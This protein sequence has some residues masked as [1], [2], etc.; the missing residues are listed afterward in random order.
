MPFKSEAQRRYMHAA[1]PGMAKRWEKETPNKSLPEKLHP[2]ESVP[3]SDYA[4]Q[5]KAKMTKKADGMFF[6]KRAQPREGRFFDQ[7]PGRDD[8]NFHKIAMYSYAPG[9]IPRGGGMNVGAASGPSYGAGA[10]SFD[11]SKV[12][13]AN[14]G[15]T[16]S[17]AGIYGTGKGKQHSKK[18]YESPTVPESDGVPTGFHRPAHEQPEALE[19]GGERFHSTQSRAP[20]YGAGTGRQSTTQQSQMKMKATSNGQLG[21]QASVRYLG[22][23]FALEKDAGEWGDIGSNFVDTLGTSS[24][25]AVDTAGKWGKNFARRAT[26]KVE[27]K[28]K[29]PAYALGALGAGALGAG[30]LGRG[31]LRGAGKGAKR[32][33]RGKPATPPPGILSRIKR[34]IVGG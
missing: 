31:L 6:E 30:L 16:G 11:P 18:A 1:H 3:R 25:Q 19:G 33:W 17:P 15:A 23:S 21:K 7:L 20:E 8:G 34:S 5:K 2:G 32:L 12:T 22:T 4:K 13:T 26:K 28:S 10:G 29:D 24:R 14:A 27:E 9:T